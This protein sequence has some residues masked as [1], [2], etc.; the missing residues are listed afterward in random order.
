MTFP[1]PADLF[2]DVVALRAAVGPG[3]AGDDDAG[4]V[5]GQARRRLQRQEAAL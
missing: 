5:P 3:L 2:C 1:A 4:A